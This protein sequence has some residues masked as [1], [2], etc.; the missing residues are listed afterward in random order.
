MSRDKIQNA[1]KKREIEVIRIFK[2]HKVLQNKMSD[3][4]TADIKNWM[5]SN[6]S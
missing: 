5:K 4:A 3:M 1:I 2:L 6:V